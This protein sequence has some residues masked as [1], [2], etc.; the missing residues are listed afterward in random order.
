MTRL[1]TVLL[2]VG[3]TAAPAYANGLQKMVRRVAVDRALVRGGLFKVL[4]NGTFTWRASKQHPGLKMRAW[5]IRRHAHQLA[6]Q[7]TSR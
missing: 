5:E 2:L 4:R 6:G 7:A 3:L 1:M